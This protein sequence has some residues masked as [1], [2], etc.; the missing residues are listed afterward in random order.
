MRIKDL[1][2]E[3]VIG[4]NQQIPF[5]EIAKIEKTVFSAARTI[6]LISIPIIL[7]MVVVDALGSIGV[8]DS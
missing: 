4:D 8:P 3:A 5:N 6:V 1:G 2:S 7:F